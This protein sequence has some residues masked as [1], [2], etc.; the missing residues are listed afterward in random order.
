MRRAGTT[1]LSL[2]TLTGVAAAQP[3][4]PAPLVLLLPAGTRALGVGNAFVAGRGSEVLFYNPAQMFILR[5]TTISVERFGSASTLGTLSTVGP[6]GKVSLGVGV[7]YLD[8]HA[9]P[10][11]PFFTQPAALTLQG[12]VNSSS[13][14]ATLALA[15]RWKGMRFGVAGKYL[16][17]HIGE[18]RDRGAAFDLGVARDVMRGTVGFS[19]QNFGSDLRLLDQEGA[20]PTRVTLGAALPTILVSSYFDFT[21]FAAVS[22]ERDG[23][24][25]P[26]AGV[27]LIYQ[28][29]DGWTLIGRAGA[30]R[31]RDLPV[32]AESPVT[33]GASFGLDRLWIDYAFQP[34]RGPGSA[35]RI[36]IRI[37]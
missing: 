3:H 9:L 24:I 13:L 11:V 20:L 23:R 10:A 30:R 25:V 36:A 35:H 7:Q 4:D 31:V 12:P 18:L 17:E 26:G 34:Y 2:L 14:A 5:G 19:V 32:R 29:V 8:Y 6:F 1:L 27:E 15:V 33:V 16:E 22:R 21:G 28:P 37:Q